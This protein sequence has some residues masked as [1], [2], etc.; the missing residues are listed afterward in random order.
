MTSRY[1]FPASPNGWFGV[2]A[3]AD[4]APGDVWPLTYL[5]RDLVLFRGE[6]G[7]ARVFDAHC[8]HL[9]AHLGVG[10]RVCGDS[11][12][13]HGLPLRRGLSVNATDASSSGTTPTAWTRAT[14]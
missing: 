12:E 13:R 1:P 6:D 11:T 10:G 8:P 4:L 14:R 2:G 3:G 5:G 9:G 7:V